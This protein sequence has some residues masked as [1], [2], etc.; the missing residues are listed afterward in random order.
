MRRVLLLQV[1]QLDPETFLAFAKSKVGKPQ[2]GQV[3]AS[4][5]ATVF[6]NPPSCK[7]GTEVIMREK[8]W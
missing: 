3:L 5:P 2:L 8:W 7:L 4:Q 6:I 1:E